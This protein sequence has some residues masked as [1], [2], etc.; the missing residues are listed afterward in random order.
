VEIE[1]QEARVVALRRHIA[2]QQW[3]SYMLDMTAH[4]QMLANNQLENGLDRLGVYNYQQYTNFMM[5][6]RHLGNPLHYADSGNAGP[7][8]A[9]LLG[10]FIV[11]ETIRETI[12]GETEREAQIFTPDGPIIVIRNI[13]KDISYFF[14]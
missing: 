6:N 13:L 12:L 11:V 14:I 3:R 9:R 1:H 4:E 5:D 2:R 10:R 8:L 7:Q